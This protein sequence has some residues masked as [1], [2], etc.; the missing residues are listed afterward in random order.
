MDPDFKTVADHLSESAH[1]MAAFMRLAG[2]SGNLSLQ[3]QMLFYHANQVVELTQ[4]IE[5]LERA[6]GMPMPPAPPSLAT[7]SQVIELE[8]VLMRDD[9]GDVG[10]GP[11]ATAPTDY[12][13]GTPRSSSAPGSAS[14][15]AAPGGK[16]RRDIAREM[17]KYL[18]RPTKM[19]RTLDRFYD[20]F[21]EDVVPRTTLGEFMRSEPDVLHHSSSNKLFQPPKGFDVGFFVRTGSFVKLAKEWVDAWE[22]HRTGGGRRS[23]PQ[24]AGDC[25]RAPHAP[26]NAV[27]P[28]SPENDV[29]S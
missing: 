24:A 16:R 14:G 12:S 15:E 23:S 10:P 28:F 20:V 8:R 26:G 27:S 29:S 6:A 21:G 18:D 1:A 5:D 17:V 7:A 22:A 19:R 11:P 2:K 4:K 3:S 13:S 9:D 25:A